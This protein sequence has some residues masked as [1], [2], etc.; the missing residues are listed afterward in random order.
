MST[1]ALARHKKVRAGH[2]SSATRLMNQ[3]EEASAVTGGPAIDKLLQ[4]KLSLTEKLTK[5]KLLDEI[6]TLVEDSAIEDEI[7]Q[8]DVFRE[9]LQQTICGVEQLIS[10]K[11]SPVPQSAIEAHHHHL[12]VPQRQVNRLQH[13]LFLTA[14]RCIPVT[15]R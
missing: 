6:L 12:K 15:A 1:E 5:L 13:H 10:L 11:S 7:E 14:P 4:W 9:R 8:A 3:V 2:R